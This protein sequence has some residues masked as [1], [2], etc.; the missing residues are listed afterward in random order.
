MIKNIVKK[1]FWLKKEEIVMAHIRYELGNSKT[2]N[3]F[4][5]YK[6]FLSHPMS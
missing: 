6:S 4:Y 2:S 5:F 3:H 1:L